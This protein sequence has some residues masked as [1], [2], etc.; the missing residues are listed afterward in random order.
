MITWMSE[1]ISH[2]YIM[3]ALLFSNN[4]VLKYAAVNNV[5]MRMISYKCYIHVVSHY[6]ELTYVASDYLT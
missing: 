4:C 5:A 1:I 2:N 6:C 3:H